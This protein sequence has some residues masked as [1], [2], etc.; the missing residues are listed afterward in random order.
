MTIANLLRSTIVCDISDAPELLLQNLLALDKSG[1]VPEVR[2][3]V[4]IWEAVRAFARLHQHV[5]ELPTVQ[6]HLVAARDLSALDYLVQQVGRLPCKTRGDFAALID[7]EVEVRRAAS[8]LETLKQVRAV[9][10]TG[11]EEGK[12]RAA[13]I[14]KGID[15]ALALLREQTRSIE[16][17][18]SGAKIS[19]EAT[20]DTR[21]LRAEYERAEM[22]SGVGNPCGLRQ[23]DTTIQGS[24]NRELWIHA[25]YSSHLKS[26]FA[27]NW[28]YHLSV[29]WQSS[30]VFF[31]LEMN[32]EQVRRQIAAMHSVHFKFREVRQALGLQPSEKLDTGLDY[33]L[34]RN[35]KLSP[36]ERKFYLDHVLPDLADE[37][38]GYGKIHVEVSNPNKPKFTM[39]DIEDRA[40]QL[41]HEDP[42][43]KLIVDHTTL[44]DPVEKYQTEREK[45]TEVAKRAKKLARGFR[46]GL[47]MDVTLLHQINRTGFQAAL[48][49][50]ESGK[51]PRY[52]MADL[53]A[54]SNAEQC[55]DVI[56]TTWLDAELSKKGLAIVDTLKARDDAKPDPFYVSMRWPCRRMLTATTVLEEPPEEPAA[57]KIRARRKP[58]DDKIGSM[59]WAGFDAPGAEVR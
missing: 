10:T 35:G 49:K 3:E 15:D 4:V 26:T 37:S 30:S 46:N 48:R 24:K 34:I 42:F 58:P 5:P 50:L 40:D 20:R 22:N 53:A 54:T 11:L 32:Y 28:C 14:R 59:T 41:Y 13:R 31:S 6:A 12:G 38:N 25:A 45:I 55:A 19:G 33:A 7:R 2:E 39:D 23:L 21:A 57:K 51:L 56:T 17:A 43:V 9:A 36:N 18:P 52:T 47:G 27:L 16:R 1:L 29:F 44:V 8:L